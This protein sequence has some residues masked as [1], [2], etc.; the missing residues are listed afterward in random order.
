MTPPKLGANNSVTG[1]CS[2]ECPGDS[3]TCNAHIQT[4]YGDAAPACNI[5]ALECMPDKL[6]RCPNG[7]M[8]VVTK[9]LPDGRISLAYKAHRS[10]HE[11][12]KITCHSGGE[13]QSHTVAPVPPQAIKHP[14]VRRSAGT[15]AQ[16]AYAV[17]SN[18]FTNL[19]EADPAG[20]FYQ[21]EDIHLTAEQIARLPLSNTS[22]P[23][24]GNY[25]H[26]NYWLRGMKHNLTGSRGRTGLFGYLDGA[27]VD[28]KIQDPEV[29]TVT[30]NATV[31]AQEIGSNNKVTVEIDG[32][33]ISSNGTA[34]LITPL[35]SGDNNDITM[36]N[37]VDNKVD[38]F[39]NTQQ[40]AA[41]SVAKVKGNR[42]VLRQL[43]TEDLTVTAVAPLAVVAGN[44]ALNT[45]DD[46][47]FIQE[48]SR[49]I[50]IEAGDKASHAAANVGYSFSVGTVANQSNISNSSVSVSGMYSSVG[51]NGG[52]VISISNATLIQSNVDNSEVTSLERFSHAAL[53]TAFVHAP[54]ARVDTTN[55]SNSKVETHGHASIAG[56]GSALMIG[57][58]NKIGLKR[59]RASHVASHGNS[60]AAGLT[61][62]YIHNLQARAD[63]ED[64]QNSTVTTQG[65]NSP[66]GM[67]IGIATGLDFHFSQVNVQ[68]TV[69]G[70][71]GSFKGGGNVGVAN[72]GGRFTQRGTSTHLET[73]ENATNSVVSPSVGYVPDGQPVEYELF[74]GSVSFTGNGT[75]ST[76]GSSNGE[77]DASGVQDTTGFA[78]NSPQSDDYKGSLERL[79]T[80]VGTKWQTALSAL[81]NAIDDELTPH[82][83]VHY[84]GERFQLLARDNSRNSSDPA[85]A[86]QRH[87]WEWCTYPEQRTGSSGDKTNL[88]RGRG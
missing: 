51:L 32:G 42:N 75:L 80:R 79:D 43:N 33:R 74:S 3:D 37:S 2:V 70:T 52:T 55:I 86:G 65:D 87:R 39:S 35:V 46:T 17:G 78:Y 21:V 59:V 6:C 48:N 62:G 77:I 34:A 38:V 72:N 68:G 56:L 50:A 82:K 27:T 12:L 4:S 60:S 84:I 76:L 41:G 26:H 54:H 40:F 10:I 20:D 44:V 19:I 85:Y 64:I 45:G 53:N 61:A 71:D 5:D 24:T 83:P 58:Y 8:D 7:Q 88:P 25:H 81:E 23:F 73:G 69:K 1:E 36:Q 30:A 67:N 49:N 9:E 28:M 63:Q 13:S 15:A 29:Q 14:M 57:K 18:N 22:T 11:P 47:T 31:F 66:A 16:K